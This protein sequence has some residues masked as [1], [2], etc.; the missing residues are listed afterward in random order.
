MVRSCNNSYCTKCNKL[1]G[2]VQIGKARGHEFT[3]EVSYKAPTN[4][5]NG[6]KVL[7]C[8]RCTE[9]IT[10]VIPAQG[11]EFELVSTE[12]ATCAETGLETY[13]CKTHTGENDCGLSYTNVIPK[14]AHTYA[15]RVKTLANCVN[16]GEGEF[17]CKV[18][19]ETFGEYDIAA[20]GHDFSKVTA[21]VASTCNTVGY[22]TKKFSRCDETETN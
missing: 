14:K 15:T 21:N 4:T 9:T 11:H 2:S 17:Y 18:C 20:L 6:E 5:E 19:G 12:D 1:E 10:V 13:R 16:A 8:S 22:V 3:V 7:K